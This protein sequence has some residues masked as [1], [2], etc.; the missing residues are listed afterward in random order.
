MSFIFDEEENEVDFNSIEFSRF[1]LVSYIDKF[2]PR[3]ENCDWLTMNFK[4]WTVYKSYRTGGTGGQ[5]FL[6]RVF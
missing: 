6:L 4:P 3:N 2:I 1:P 5:G